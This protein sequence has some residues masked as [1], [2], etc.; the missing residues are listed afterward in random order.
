MIYCYKGFLLIVGVYMAWETRH[1]KIP[2]LND[3]QY[4]GICVYS[5]V[6]S[7]IVVVLSNFV[8]DYITLSYLATALSILTSTTITLVLLF[9]P[10]LKSVLGR[11]DG[12]N[13]IAQSMGLKVECNTRRLIF[14]DQRELLHRMEIQNAVYKNEIEL[15]DKEIARLEELLA[16]SSSSKSA[17]SEPFTISNGSIFL[18]V[19]FFTPSRAS[20][21]ST[22]KTS[23]IPKCFLSDNKLNRPNEYFCETTNIFSKFKRF[24]GS[25]PTLRLL[26]PV[27]PSGHCQFM[28]KPTSSPQFFVET[29]KQ[30]NDDDG[31]KAKSTTSILLSSNAK[32]AVASSETANPMFQ[33]E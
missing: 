17:I 1:V 25:I 9:L 4:I 12:E 8:A 33:R 26:T 21:P 3:S 20:W 7:S 27:A 32:N 23:T 6:S 13:A 19:P 22:T 10:K 29:L 2:S 28:K 5:V 24:F 11:T 18:P 16:S 14:D 15:L 30:M 31:I